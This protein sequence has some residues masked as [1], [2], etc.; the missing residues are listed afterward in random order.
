MIQIVFFCIFTQPPDSL[1]K[2]NVYV[3]ADNKLHFVDRE[4]ADSVLPFNKNNFIIDGKNYIYNIDDN[5]Y[6]SV[7]Y[8]S[9]NFK[10][11][12]TKTYYIEF[13]HDSQDVYS[14]WKLENGTITNTSWKGWNTG[15]FS[16]NINNGVLNM[17]GATPGHLKISV[18]K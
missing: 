3:G 6:L 12:A 4:G 13:I 7:N 9:I 14:N 16:H 17:S 10:F 11:D 1:D 18:L 15:Y 8:P 2:I 5:H